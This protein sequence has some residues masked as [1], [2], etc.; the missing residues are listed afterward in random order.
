MRRMLHNRPAVRGS[1]PPVLACMLLGAL[2]SGAGPTAAGGGPLA[3]WPFDGNALDVSGNGLDGTLS[4]ALPA[5]DRFGRAGRAL[6]FDGGA[7]VSVAHNPLLDLQGPMTVSLWI[8]ADSI[9]A[10]GDRMI[11][12]KS[13]YASAT[14]FLLR[15]RPGG[16]LQWEYLDYTESTER[17]LLPAVWHHLA[18]TAEGPGLVKR[19]FIDGTEVMTSTPPGTAFGLVSDP[20]TFGHASYGAEHLV[21]SLDEV[22]LYAR[23]LTQDEILDLVLEDL[24]VFE[25]GFE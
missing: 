23:A 8:R 7:G 1:R 15:I 2:L 6:H 12:G 10:S 14:N 19:I 21:G 18:V 11:L 22:R 13:N 3:H 20:L 24:V 16:F 5:P 4:F 17:P 9:Q 25:D